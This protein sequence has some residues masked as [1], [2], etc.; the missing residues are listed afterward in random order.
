MNIPRKYF[1]TDGIRGN[2]GRDPITAHFMLKLGWA[3]GIVL[4]NQGGKKVLIGK[5][6]RISGYMIESALQAGLTSAGMK[7][8]LVGPMPTSAIAYLTQTF[9]ADI[10]IVISASHNPYD[11]N[12]IKLFSAKGFKLPESFELAIEKML[13][14]PMTTADSNQ[15]GKAW[16]IEDAAGR[17]IEYCKSVL[18]RQMHLKELKLVI[19][20]ANGATYHIAPYVFAELGANVTSINTAPNGF[21]INQNC[22]S[23]HPEVIQNQV[24]DK[25]ADVGIAF[26]G[27]GDRV[28]LVD[29]RGE[30]LDGNEI[31]YII[32]KGLVESG[33]YSGGIV[34]THM[35]NG[36]LEQA[37]NQLGLAF[38]RVN[39]GSQYVVR[40]LL[41]KQWLLGG[42]PSGHITFLP[43]NT[44]DD[45]I[46]TALLVLKAMRTTGQTL[47]ELK[48][49]MQKFPQ[50]VTKILHNHSTLDLHQP[51]IIHFVKQAE[52]RL[53]KYGRVILRY[54]G[55][56]SVIRIMVE[57]EDQ[58]QVDKIIQDL[59]TLIQK[60]LLDPL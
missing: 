46:I 55:T 42:E 22:G 60:K 2:V 43:M 24:L 31:L 30:M 36:G 20:C 58:T 12:G 29:H 7:I 35:S 3:I 44:T 9:S 25:K 1:G 41:E 18:P 15:L 16:R 45:G 17:Y 39:V 23:N 48:K 10:G 13:E 34:G 57:G 19:D 54:S 52:M 11:D 28:V 56:E 38:L 37:L 21:N 14:E 32:A 5:D 8:N 50:R 40:A 51:D 26:D 47:H 53:G 49:G 33:E 4:G 59:D 27:D 6:P